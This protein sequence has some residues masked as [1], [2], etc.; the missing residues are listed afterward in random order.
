M[1]GSRSKRPRRE[2]HW[3]PR[4]LLI[5]DPVNCHLEVALGVSME[6]LQMVVLR[7]VFHAGLPHGCLVSGAEAEGCPD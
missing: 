1:A 7:E 3:V 6:G 2:V 4:C 5:L